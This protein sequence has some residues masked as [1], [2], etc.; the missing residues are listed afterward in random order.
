MDGPSYR[1]RKRPGP[2]QLDTNPDRRVDLT[3]QAHLGNYVTNTPGEL[4]DG[5][6]DRWRYVGRRPKRFP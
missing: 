6:T 1:P 5:D 3:T 2:R 4:R